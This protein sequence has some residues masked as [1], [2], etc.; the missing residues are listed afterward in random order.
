MLAIFFRLPLQMANAASN[1]EQNETHYTLL[2]HIT[3]DRFSQE[4]KHDI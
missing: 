1:R 3:C 2:T 4:I